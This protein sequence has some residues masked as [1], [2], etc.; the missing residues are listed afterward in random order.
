[1]K[2]LIVLLVL[3][4]VCFFACKK[5]DTMPIIVPATE[6]NYSS[7]DSIHIDTSLVYHGLIDQ[8]FYDQVNNKQYIVK[9]NKA[10]A[11]YTFLRDTFF[12]VISD[13]SD[14]NL[15]NELYVMIKNKSISTIS[16]RYDFASSDVL[17]WWKQGLE[18]GGYFIQ[19]GPINNPS[20]KGSILIEYDPSTK[21]ISG[22]IENLKYK[23]G[24]YIP[25]IRNGHVPS[26]YAYNKHFLVELGSTRNQEIKF[27]YVKKQ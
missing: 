24:I 25:V 12:L 7:V 16:G 20:L 2:K 3:S 26:S 19:P 17:F 6:V 22:Q 27:K 21:M 5:E 10:G 4:F 9:N 18:R 1:M 23:F 14:I 13:T 8:D 15:E 11:N